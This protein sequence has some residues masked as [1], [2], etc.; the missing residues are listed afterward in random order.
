MF[1]AITWVIYRRHLYK[2]KYKGF[3][4]S[5][6]SFVDANSKFSEFNRLHFASIVK[7][8][9]LGRFTYV[10][11]A[12]IQ[13]ATIGNFCSIGPGS[14]VGGLGHHPTNWVSTHPVFYSRNKQS[15]ARFSDK[16]YFTETKRVSIG[17]DVWI[18]AKAIVLDGVN[19]GDGAV[20]AA[21]AV[22]TQDVQPYAIVGGVPAKLIRFRFEQNIIDALV[23]SCWWT[24]SEDKLRG[25]LEIFRV[26]PTD[27]ILEIL[28]SG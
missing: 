8:S 28:K 17:N 20:I 12:R 23:A 27:E 9:I 6:F 25:K 19:I 2:W 14:R 1:D 26:S 15:N 5:F 11:G 22:V 3:K 16:N 21:G 4:S 24:W 13:S 18:G 10:A 7:D